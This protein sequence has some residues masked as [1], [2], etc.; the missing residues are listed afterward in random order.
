MVTEDAALPFF[1][2]VLF[3]RHFQFCAKKIS[4][5]NYPLLAKLIVG[6]VYRIATSFPPILVGIGAWPDG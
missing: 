4:P 3:R 1:N 6:D 5:T 2:T